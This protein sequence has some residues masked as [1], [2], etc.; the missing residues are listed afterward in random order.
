MVRFLNTSIHRIEELVHI[1]ILRYIIR[2]GTNIQRLRWKL[3]QMLSML[4]DHGSRRSGAADKSSTR[5]MN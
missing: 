2:P 1:K 3:A 4:S 5:D